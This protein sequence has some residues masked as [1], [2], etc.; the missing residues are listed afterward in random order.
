[1]AL[2]DRAV[3]A[4]PENLEVRFLRGMTNYGVPRFFGRRDIAAKDLAF[5]AERAGAA[6]QAGGLGRP[7][8]A[9][10]LYHYGMLCDETGHRAAA[11][12][13]CRAACEVGPDTPSGRAAA[14]WLAD[15]KKSR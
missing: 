1:M 9:A 15:A 4:E 7:L 8:A 3:T 10:A 6:A 12:A 2:L 5:V 11:A 14:R 13:S